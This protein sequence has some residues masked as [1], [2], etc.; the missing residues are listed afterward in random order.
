MSIRFLPLS[1][2]IFK[3]LEY[4]LETEIGSRKIFQNMWFLV[5]RGQRHETPNQKSMNVNCFV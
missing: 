4:F 3:S 1:H 2:N 5:E